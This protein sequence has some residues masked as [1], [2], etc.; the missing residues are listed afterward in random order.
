MTESLAAWRTKSLAGDSPCTRPA[1]P[2]HLDP[3]R[4]QVL[5]WSRVAEGLLR[6]DGVVVSPGPRWAAPCGKGPDNEGGRTGG[7]LGGEFCDPEAQIERLLLLL[8]RSI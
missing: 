6:A 2:L 4:G 7:F 3:D 8:N 5:G 1:R